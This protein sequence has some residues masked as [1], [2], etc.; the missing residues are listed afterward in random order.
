MRLQSIEL[1]S[2]LK[3]KKFHAYKIYLVQELWGNYN[4]RYLHFVKK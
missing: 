4:N 2:I 3:Q 1:M